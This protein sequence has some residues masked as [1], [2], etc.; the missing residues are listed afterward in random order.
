[1]DERHPM[2]PVDINGIHKAAAEAYHLLYGRLYDLRPTSLRHNNTY[3]PGQLMRHG[4]QGFA[5]WLIRLA[6]EGKR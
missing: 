6:I 3:G 1:V 4:R 2:R 5:P